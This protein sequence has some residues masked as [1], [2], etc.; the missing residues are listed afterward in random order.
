MT[1]I[2]GDIFR[3]L[4]ISCHDMEKGEALAWDI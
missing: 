1:S 2:P 3:R 4:T